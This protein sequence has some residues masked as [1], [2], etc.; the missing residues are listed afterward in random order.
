M[1]EKALRKLKR[2]DLLQ[3]LVNQSREIDRLESELKKAW[4][5]VAEREIR[6]SRCG[7]LAEASLA[8]YSVLE[9]A[10]KAADLYVENAK[11][12]TDKGMADQS[13]ISHGSLTRDN[14]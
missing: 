7:S 3:I 9:N 11:R 13:S 12:M 6:V 4:D 2:K 10:Q 8:I 14:I 1:D 5:K